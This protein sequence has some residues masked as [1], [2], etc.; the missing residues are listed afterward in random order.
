MKWCLDVGGGSVGSGREWMSWVSDGNKEWYSVECVAAVS[1]VEVADDGSSVLC[2]EELVLAAVVGCGDAVRRRRGGEIGRLRF[3]EIED[4]TV[5]RD[6][7]MLCK[8]TGGQ[9]VEHQRWY[10]LQTDQ[11]GSG[12]V[13]MMRCHHSEM[14]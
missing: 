5:I 11:A 1:V 3:V 2:V 9:T 10:P 12:M 4:A 8:R 6:V 13:G 7:V 14:M